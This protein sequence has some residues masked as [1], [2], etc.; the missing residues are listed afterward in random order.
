MLAHDLIKLSSDVPLIDK[1]ERVVNP[2]R[3]R[4]RVTNGRI[5]GFLGTSQPNFDGFY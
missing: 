1:G 5:C 4:C 3:D 2:A